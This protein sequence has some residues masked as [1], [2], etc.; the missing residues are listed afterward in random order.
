MPLFKKKIKQADLG[1]PTPE[2]KVR[3]F[4]DMPESPGVIFVPEDLTDSNADVTETANTGANVDENWIKITNGSNTARFFRK[5]ECKLLVDLETSAPAQ[6]TNGELAFYVEDPNST[7][8]KNIH[9]MDLAIFDTLSNQRN[10]L[11]QKPWPFNFALPPNYK[12]YLKVKSA[13]ILSTANSKLS[14]SNV[15]KANNVTLEDF[16][17]NGYG[18]WLTI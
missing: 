14:I 6:I 11:Y 5:G 9:R 2:I 15:N 18:E 17:K 16:K 7:R 13:S 3:N 4:G 10:Q 8:L 12:L 1:K